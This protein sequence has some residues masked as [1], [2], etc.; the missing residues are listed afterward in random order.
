MFVVR[1]VKHSFLS[2]A[3]TLT[4]VAFFLAQVGA[5]YYKLDANAGWRVV[6]CVGSVLVRV[7]G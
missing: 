7:S 5:L 4:Y 6:G 3:G 1:T 2:R